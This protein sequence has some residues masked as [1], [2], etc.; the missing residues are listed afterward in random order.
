MV[1]STPRVCL[2]RFAA[3]FTGK[4]LQLNTKQRFKIIQWVVTAS[5]AGTNPM[6]HVHTVLSNDFHIVRIALFEA[7]DNKW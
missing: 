5:L 4:N 6:R 7:Q 3:G 2:D 1:S